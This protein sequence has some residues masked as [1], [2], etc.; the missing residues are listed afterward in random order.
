MHKLLFD[1]NLSFKLIEY[2]KEIF[3]ESTHVSFIKLDTSEDLVLWQYAK[4]NGYHIVTKD[5]DFNDI[6][7]LYGFPPKI[8]RINIGNTS[9]KMILKLLE[10]KISLIKDFLDNEHVG[11]LEID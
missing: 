5:I 6:N 8:I 7:I 11:Y 10:N 1:Q 2:I 4:D 9:T 3:P